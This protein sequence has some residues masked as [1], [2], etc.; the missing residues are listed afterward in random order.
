MSAV[1]GKERRRESSVVQSRRLAERDK[2]RRDVGR[3]DGGG[4]G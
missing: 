3:G 1:K 4:I 2:R